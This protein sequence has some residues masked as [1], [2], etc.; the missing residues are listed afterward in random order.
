[1]KSL[2]AKIISELSA[3]SIKERF[4]DDKIILVTSSGVISGT[5][6]L[7]DTR[8]S[9]SRCTHQFVQSI[10]DAHYR[11]LSENTVSNNDDFIELEDA[12][13]FAGAVE[14]RFPHLVVFFDQIV[15]ASLGQ[16]MINNR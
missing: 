14:H 16:T 2:K 4:P 12:V 1:M 11:S 3:L 7:N 13:L 5:P 8:S 10:K 6:I 9:A 15:A